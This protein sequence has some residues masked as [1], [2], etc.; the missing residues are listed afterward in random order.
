MRR[1]F[2]MDNPFWQAL[3]VVADMMLLNLLTLLCCVPV[4]TVGAAFTA[5][6]AVV[7]RILRQEENGI[8]KSYGR[9]FRENL[10]KG[11]L[12]GLILLAAAGLL[13]FDYLCALAYAPVFRYGIAAI[14]VLVLAV[15]IYTFALLA[16]YENSLGRTIRNAA[17]LAVG[18]FPQT[19]GM[20]LFTAVLWLLCIR[21]YRVGA[22]VLFL[23]GFSLP[24][25][26]A[27]TLM[28]PIFDRLDAKSERGEE[29][30]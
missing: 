4:I 5:M 12:F 29:S 3:S 15:S 11:G 10:K 14:C 19:L 13:Y 17:M 25:Y 26:V 2:D 24:C 27:A 16:R 20:V 6:N 7:I 22:P 18:Y 30:V 23:F 8:L 1:I 28:R 9:A 21:Y